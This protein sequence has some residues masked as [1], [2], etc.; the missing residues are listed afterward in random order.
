MLSIEEKP[1]QP[2]SNY[3]VVGLYFYPNSV[4]QVAEKVKPSLRAELEIT[5]VNQSYL[6][7][8]NLYV[9]AGGNTNIKESKTITNMA[10]HI[11]VGLNFVK[12][13]EDKYEIVS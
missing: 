13:H 10:L 4:V 2:K 11:L 6:E 12:R 3:A 5:S 7:A 9:E 8:D 1:T